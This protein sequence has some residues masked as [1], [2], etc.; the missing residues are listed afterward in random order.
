MSLICSANFVSVSFVVCVFVSSLFTFLNMHTNVCVS[1]V[2]TC[3][4]KS[5]A[6]M[7][8]MGDSSCV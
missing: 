4:I 6:E 8:E 2:F 7:I 1:G 3:L 5:I